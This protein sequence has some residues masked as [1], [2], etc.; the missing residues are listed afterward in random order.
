MFLED[1]GKDTDDEY[2]FVNDN[3]WVAS[4]YVMCLSVEDRL[5]LFFCCLKNDF[6]YGTTTMLEVYG[7]ELFKSLTKNHFNQISRDTVTFPWI[8][9]E[10]NGAIARYNGRRE[11]ETTREWRTDEML[12]SNFVDGITFILS[13][14]E[15]IGHDYLRHQKRQRGA[16]KDAICEAC[17]NIRDMKHA[18]DLELKT[19]YELHKIG[20]IIQ[21]IA[22][23]LCED[24]QITGTTKYK[25]L[26]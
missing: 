17:T 22:C 3:S 4:R 24:K 19:F 2:D 15:N 26:I 13:I 12:K 11:T 18:S 1:L 25:K 16:D 6:C 5:E 8:A 7:N 20:L 14:L 23:W 9:Y 10:I 21:R